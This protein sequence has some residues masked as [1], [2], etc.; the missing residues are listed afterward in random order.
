M[1]PLSVFP[2]PNS[3]SREKIGYACVKNTPSVLRGC[4]VGVKN[5]FVGIQCSSRVSTWNSQKAP[6]YSH[7]YRF[8]SAI[9]S[10]QYGQLHTGRSRSRTYC[11]LDTPNAFPC[12]IFS[13]AARH[14]CHSS[15]S[16][17]SAHTAHP[18]RSRIH[19]AKGESSILARREVF[20]SVK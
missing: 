18:S 1:N 15:S 20:N 9:K 13:H 10:W 11:S 4:A 2:V 19:C 3:Q 6:F 7:P 16:P 8:A 5:R 12:L 17:A 14:R